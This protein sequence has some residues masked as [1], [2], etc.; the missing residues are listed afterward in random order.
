MDEDE[1]TFDQIKDISDEVSCL[2]EALLK[3]T[4]TVPIVQDAKSNVQ[5]TLDTVQECMTEIELDAL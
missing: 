5:K 3:V 1:V 2:R 4:R